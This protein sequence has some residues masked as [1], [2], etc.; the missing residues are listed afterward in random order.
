M[1]V[2]PEREDILINLC[3]DVLGPRSGLNEILYSDP[4][5]EYV[6]GVLAPKTEI[7]SR[8]IEADGE[9]DIDEASGE[10]DEHEAAAGTSDDIISPALQPKA[11]PR[12]I[13]LSFLI[14]NEKEI[15]SVEICT[16][17]ARYVKDS[18]DGGW[19]RK[20]FFKIVDSIKISDQNWVTRDSMRLVMRANE[21]KDEANLW[22]VSVFLVNDIELQDA[23]EAQPEHFVFQPEIRI[24]ACKDS[25]IAPLLSHIFNSVPDEED[26]SLYLED[27]SLTLLYKGRPA[28]ARGHLTGATWR[29]IDP[30]RPH[31]VKG[32]L[33]EPPFFWVDS[34]VV[35]E[36]KR[37]KFL[38]PDIRTDFLPMYPIE[39]PDMSWKQKYGPQPELSPEVLAE[40]WEPTDIKQA[41][42]PIVNGYQM[43]LEEK[44]AKVVN[45]ADARYRKTAD[46][47]LLNVKEAINRIKQGIDLIRSD[48]EVRLAFCFAN[49]AIALQ[50]KWS[51][52]TV[53]NW[54]LFQ[55]AFILLN[56]SGITSDDH[57]DRDICDLLWFATGGGKTEAYLGL[58]AFT[59]GLRRLRAER[60]SKG[61][62]YGAGTA[63]IS[64]YTLR[65][66]TIQQFRRALGIL[67]ACE[68]LRVK[69][70]DES[71]NGWRPQKV[72]IYDNYLWGTAKFSAGLWVGGNVTP[73]NIEGFSFRREDGR[74]QEIP[75][76]IDLLQRDIS[77]NGEPAQVLNCP[78]CN[79]VL[80]IQ[81]EGLCK[82][83]HVMHFIV[84]SRRINNPV[85]DD[86]KLR[87]RLNVIS[88]KITAQEKDIKTISIE[89]EASNNN[90]LTSKVIDSWWRDVVSVKLGLLDSSL[91]ATRASRPGYIFMEYVNQRGRQVPND[92]IIICPNPDCDLNNDVEWKEKVPVCISCDRIV[93][94]GQIRN[95]YDFQTVPRC[96]RSRK[97]VD[98]SNR[99]PIPAFTVDEQVY[100]HCPTMLIATAD[101]YAR[102]PFEPMA[103]SI[104]GNVE[105]YHSRYGYYRKYCLRPRN[106]PNC[107]R[108]HPVQTVMHK[109]IRKFP[110]PALIIQDEL[111]LIEG[112]LG[113][114][115]GI[116]ETAIEEL[117]K[118]TSQG[119]IKPKY[120]VSTA[121]VRQASAQVQSLFQR[122][123]G[124]FPPSGIT[125]DDNFFSTTQETHPL[126][127]DKPGRLY[128]GICAPGKGA[129]TPL[130]RIYSACLQ[131]PYS[132]RMQGQA[133]D[134]E[135]DGFWTLIG[136]FNAI[137]E[138]AGAVALLRQDIP[139]RLSTLHSPNER[140]I[141][142][143]PL[144][145]SS[146]KDSTEL[147]GLLDALAVNL[148]SNRSPVDVALTT[149]MFGTGVDVDRLKLM[150]VNGQP[151]STA[152]YI[153]ATG[154]VGRSGGGL[155]ISFFRASRP[156]DLA[157]YEFFSGY[158][159]ALYKYVEPVTVSPFSPR[160]RERSLGPLAVILL[161]NASE[162]RGI[163]V[164]EEWRY[165]QRLNNGVNACNAGRMANERLASEVQAIINLVVE[166]ATNQPQGRRPE[167][168]EIE[169]EIASELDR[170]QTIARIHGDA[171][172]YDES[173]MIR[174]PSSPVV[175][176]DAQHYFQ[177][178]DTVYRNTPQ[179]LRDVE[180]ITRFKS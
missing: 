125:I 101:K 133:T 46:R 108:E 166:R 103:A 109:R 19:K 13:G 79:S 144:E 149:S 84:Q 102:L 118:L 82:G 70:W 24:V 178:L 160:A 43:W 156:R 119:I 129:Q 14:Y 21:I 90:Q 48:E 20:P 12:S 50:S 151:K 35:P 7:E 37:R 111:H 40:M 6:T 39:A 25:T 128:V 99:I 54:R 173:S 124:Q 83:I 141:P 22:R 97:R 147:P 138:L 26:I 47:H 180:A 176:G 132:R 51:R 110:P 174:I 157:H 161:R 52:G 164:P 150:V 56:I 33:L 87:E 96:L 76:A 62:R 130:V 105:Y 167:L 91:Q 121:T 15:P 131:R 89:F 72:S 74:I 100:R 18:Q 81:K 23:R 2:V 104:F 175:L 45:Q 9:L 80:A 4:R 75:G 113:S 169:R 162:I 73:N 68:F 139:Q 53:F 107:L 122:D 163:Q 28:L 11:L 64:R 127:S 16:T 165:Q 71:K 44:N 57:P 10:E 88:C 148:G 170:W 69:K 1:I 60:D 172:L 140:P 55:L 153:Q 3:K 29:D 5:G 98:V 93:D 179:S 146:R 34:E 95:D 78:C 135:L 49:K 159:R 41:L 155:V 94:D 134:K 137:R 27:Q 58:A 77:H 92:F 123:F 112:P 143:D 31:P 142:K 42:Y 59:I 66:L 171:L 36:D 168:E 106:N 17:W 117:C 116:Y 152:S 136:Y 115:T 177:G 61:L 114:M 30:Q 158:H 154:R 38:L 67:T 65:L 120:I 8:D 126:D 145:L 63:V 86:L 32:K 85:A